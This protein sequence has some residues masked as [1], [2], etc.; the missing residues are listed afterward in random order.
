MSE[1]EDE[2]VGEMK[3]EALKTFKEGFKV[4]GEYKMEF[5]GFVCPQDFVAEFTPLEFEEVR[6]LSLLRSI[7]RANNQLTIAD[8]SDVLRLRQ[9]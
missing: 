5:N 6:L 8:C 9:Q 3:G 4:E 2:S 1:E 7:P